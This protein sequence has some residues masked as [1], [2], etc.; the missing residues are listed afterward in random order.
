MFCVVTGFMGAGKATSHLKSV[1]ATMCLQ[2][3]GTM[4]SQNVEHIF[5]EKVFSKWDT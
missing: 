4:A 2:Q 1:L 3:K 5:L